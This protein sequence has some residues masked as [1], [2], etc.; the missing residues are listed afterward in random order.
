MSTVRE[1]AR[2]VLSAQH[3][4]AKV[5]SARTAYRHLLAL[6]PRLLGPPVPLALSPP[7]S[8]LVL[9]L[10]RLPLQHSN[11]EISLL[12]ALAHIEYNAINLYWDMLGRFELD[13]IPDEYYVEFASVACDEADHLEAL[14]K[15]LQALGSA[16]GQLGVHN[17]LITGLEASSSSV[18]DRIALTALV[19][20]ARALDS[21]KRLVSK[22]NS[23][24]NDKESTRLLEWIV[25]CEVKHVRVGLK[26]FRHLAGKEGKQRFR[27]TVK[28]LVGRLRPPFD[29]M[30]RAEAGFP[31]DWYEA[32]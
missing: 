21:R 29:H 22:L 26:W 19:H 5:S 16:Y 12:H 17:A 27:E 10:Q 15:R 32:E 8:S 18:L 2:S 23:F 20:E 30:S 3:T 28:R 24:N 7:P 6:S 25:D 1:L 9:P 14:D 13:N 11:K 31:R 4:Q